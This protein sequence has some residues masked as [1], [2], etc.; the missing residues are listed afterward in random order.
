MKFFARVGGRKV[1]CYVAAQREGNTNTALRLPH[2][3]SAEFPNDN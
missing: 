3:N 2:P 1:H